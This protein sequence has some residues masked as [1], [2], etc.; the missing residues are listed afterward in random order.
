MEGDQKNSVVTFVVKY[1]SSM[2]ARKSVRNVPRFPPV[3]V[4]KPI[5]TLSVVT[6]TLSMTQVKLIRPGVT[7]LTNGMNA[8][9]TEVL[10]KLST[11]YGNDIPCPLL[12]G[13]L[14]RPPLY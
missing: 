9:T 7:V 10:T 13:T 1:T 2:D 5:P 6:V 3:T 8:L 12:V 4:S 14:E 11:N